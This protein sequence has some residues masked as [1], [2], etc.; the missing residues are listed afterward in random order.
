MNDK[1]TRL[2]NKTKNEIISISKHSPINKKIKR[3]N[4]SISKNNNPSSPIK[5]KCK[6]PPISEILGLPTI[7]ESNSLHDRP[8]HLPQGI[9]VKVVELIDYWNSLD[10]TQKHKNPTTKIYRRIAGLLKSLQSGAFGKKHPVDEEFMKYHKIESFYLHKPFSDSDIQNGMIGL[11]L[12]LTEGHGYETNGVIWPD[13]EYKQA[14][15]KYSLADLIYKRVYN[16]SYT[17]YKEPISWFLRVFACPPHPVGSIF[18]IDYEK[19][20]FKKYFNYI[21]S[22][23]SVPPSDKDKKL[24]SQKLKRI[25]DAYSKID[26]EN[27]IRTNFKWDSI[28]LGKKHYERFI[29]EYMRYI[30]ETYE[31]NDWTISTKSIGIGVKSWSNFLLF[32]YEE[33]N[34]DIRY[35]NEK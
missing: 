12:L 34:I 35:L 6:I 5:R 18:S 14:L 17:K 30:E 28:M 19:P 13:P 25:I 33:F 15:R 27:P 32:L 7:D 29:E 2:K 3:F 16:P 26:F 20:K 21:C 24:L 4:S 1:I 31:Y 10:N 8:T 9:T 23:L 22:L 11:S